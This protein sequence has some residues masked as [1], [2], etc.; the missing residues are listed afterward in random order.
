MIYRTTGYNNQSMLNTILE[1]QS[2][3]FD[4]YTK[5]NNN[6][7]FSNIS[8]NPIDAT[9]VININTAL[10]KIE[11][12]QK[13]IKNAS[14]QINVQDS[15]FST[16]ISKMDRINELAIQAA[17]GASGANGIDAC[18]AEIKSLKE[19]IVALANTEYNGI[20]IFGG[21]NTGTPP[22]V[23]EADGSITYHGTPAADTSYKRNVEISDGV[24]VNVNAAGDEVFGN[25]DAGDPTQTP[26]VA[27]SGTGLFKVLGDL[28]EAL[29]SGDTTKITAQ[30][31]NIQAASKN[32]SEIQSIY[33][34]NVAKLTMTET[35][36]EDRVLTLKSQK[37]NLNEIDQA[38]AISAWVK[39]NYAY[40]ASM[41][42]FMQMQN[43]SLLNYM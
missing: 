21:A 2:K 20:Y 11:T 6:E 8:E 12:F 22:Y 23:L 36:L 28:E 35:N 15:T 33:S 43:N 17:N 4:S 13:N 42:T 9:G 1:Q 24:Y 18:K 5:I 14:T 39:Q 37:Q 7:K 27:P 25:Y 32:V 40:Q 30:L 26:P 41:Q 34:A 3:L 29:N 16:V 10:M 19:N 38:T 31:D